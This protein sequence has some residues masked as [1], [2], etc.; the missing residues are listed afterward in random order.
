MLSL[1]LL[2]QAHGII[3]A[4][5]TPLPERNTFYGCSGC[6]LRVQTRTG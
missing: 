4:T 5:R 2:P 6:P 1:S 3:A